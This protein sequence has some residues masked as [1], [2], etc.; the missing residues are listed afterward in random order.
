MSYTSKKQASKE[1]RARQAIAKAE[2]HVKTAGKQQTSRLG[3]SRFC[4]CCDLNA[5]SS[6]AVK[7]SMQQQDECSPL[8]SVG[9]AKNRMA[10]DIWG[11][12]R[13]G[14]QFKR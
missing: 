3:L 1:K 12:R 13:E 8:E 4:F 6:R 10:S 9:Y 7:E 11:A 2:K 14:G 5:R